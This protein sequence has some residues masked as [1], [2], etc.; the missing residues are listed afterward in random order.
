MIQ[1][2]SSWLK[3]LRPAPMRWLVPVETPYRERAWDKSIVRKRSVHLPLHGAGTRSKERE[4][5]LRFLEQIHGELSG[6][7]I[8]L[9]AG[10]SHLK[11]LQ[12]RMPDVKRVIAHDVVAYEGVDLVCDLSDLSSRLP[13]GSLDAATC[14]EVL[15]HLEDPAAA[16]REIFAVL[17][18]GGSL[19]L[20]TP[21][22]YPIHG[23]KLSDG[24]LDYWRFT[25]H[26]LRKLLSPYC[27]DIRIQYSGQRREE[28]ISYCVACVKR[29]AAGAVT[30]P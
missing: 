20:T 10:R 27:D 19:Y 8:D 17:K 11:R 18:P 6:E 3:R 25:E 21:F 2:V 28:P 22:Q 26:G 4:S 30:A 24:R 12:H 13:P 15:E 23:W 29:P 5:M 14:F 7:V 1:K 9:G 16:L